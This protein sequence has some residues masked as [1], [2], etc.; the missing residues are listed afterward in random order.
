MN[1]SRFFGKTKGERIE[2]S[3]IQ[4]NGFMKRLVGITGIILM[5]CLF[6]STMFAPQAAQNTEIKQVTKSVNVQEE[7]FVLKS[8]DNCLVV[9]KK[10]E[11]VPY[12]ITDT[13]VNN[14]PKGDIMLLERGI[15][16][17]GEKNLKKSLEDY[18][19]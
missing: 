8:E 7:V 9:Y 12:M 11:T 16:I 10:G 17:E 5:I 6:T 14:L 3:R 13:S 2:K 4:R 1:I 15:E 19:S 18:C